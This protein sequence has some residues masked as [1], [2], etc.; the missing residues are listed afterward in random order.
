MS[1]GPLYSPF[2]ELNRLGK[3]KVAKVDKGIELEVAVE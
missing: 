1:I 2:R 3:I